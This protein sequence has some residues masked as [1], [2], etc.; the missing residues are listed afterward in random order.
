MW[1]LVRPAGEATTLTVEAQRHGS[2]RFSKLAQVRT[3]SRGYWT[4]SSTVAAVR[5]RVRWVGPSGR[6]YTG[7]AI[8]AN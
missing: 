6:V 4:L 1:G 8:G 3:D 5:W 7:P 2:R